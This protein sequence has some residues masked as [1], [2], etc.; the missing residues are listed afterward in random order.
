MDCMPL[1]SP[2][3]FLPVSVPRYPSKRLTNPASTL[4]RILLSYGLPR[5]GLGLGFGLRSSL[6]LRRGPLGLG[7]SDSDR[8]REQKL[9]QL[10]EFLGVDMRDGLGFGDGLGRLGDR[11][12]DLGRLGG[13]RLGLGLGSLGLGSLNDRGTLE[14]RFARR[15]RNELM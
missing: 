9:R 3:L 14:E 2:L 4:D 7:P 15:R 8:N 6:D 1:P 13:G 12:G 5:E 10:F 11:V